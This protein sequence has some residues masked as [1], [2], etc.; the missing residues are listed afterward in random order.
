MFVVKRNIRA[1]SKCWD[2]DFHFLTEG[3]SI[4]GN[5]G[6][7]K[8]VFLKRDTIKFSAKLNSQRYVT[9]REQEVDRV[10]IFNEKD[11]LSGQKRN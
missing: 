11:L 7:C 2:V 10:E 9:I 3:D 1:T 4:N 5:F 6:V 8:T